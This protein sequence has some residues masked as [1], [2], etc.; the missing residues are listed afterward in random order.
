MRNQ[1]IWELLWLRREVGFPTSTC[2]AFP[3]VWPVASGILVLW[4][5][6]KRVVCFECVAICRRA[7]MRLSPN[8]FSEVLPF[9]LSHVPFLN[10]TYAL[11]LPPSLQYLL[12]FGSFIVTQGESAIISFFWV[13]SLISL[14]TKHLSMLWFFL[15]FLFL[16]CQLAI[17]V[18]PATSLLA[19]VVTISYYLGYLIKAGSL[20]YVSKLCQRP[21]R[22]E[23]ESLCLGLCPSRDQDLV[24]VHI[25]THSQSQHIAFGIA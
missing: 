9:L 6:A 5:Q 15:L 10:Y 19:W 18:V 11:V 2:S 12:E 21:G 22:G 17:I 20:L 3:S 14:L 8:F 7:H 25:L 23:S 4:E 1:K 24:R 13:I 16:F